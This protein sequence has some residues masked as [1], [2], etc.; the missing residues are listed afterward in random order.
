M[1]KTTPP[2]GDV[3]WFGSSASSTP[4]P[5]TLQRNSVLCFCS[6]T[7][8]LISDLLVPLL[9]C[10]C[11]RPPSGP[12]QP[13]VS[14]LS[15]PSAPFDLSVH[16]LDLFPLSLSP[17]GHLARLRWSIPVTSLQENPVSRHAPDSRC[18]GHISQTHVDTKDGKLWDRKHL[19]K[20]P[21]N[22]G[23]G[24]FRPLA[25]KLISKT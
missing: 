22:Q 24:Q 2:A 15:P 7:G 14:S 16:M 20:H 12:G 6:W 11:S 23:G 5:D 18:S 25:V 4:C 13:S 9:L 17:G 8:I 10:S 21:D 1:E 3:W 19:E